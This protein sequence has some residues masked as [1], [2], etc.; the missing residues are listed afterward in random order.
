[1]QMTFKMR[2]I[3]WL[4]FLAILISCGTNGG[5][6]AE[7]ERQ[8]KTADSIS[9]KLNSPELKAINAKIL[10][11]PSNADLY[12]QR[13]IVYLG[14]REFQEAVNDSKR[15]IRIDSLQPPY[16]LTLADVY[17]AQNNTRL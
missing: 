1:M 7:L 17:F 13:S 9:I 5:D 15:A 4:P 11:D 10:A 8:S 16:Y 6:S 3:C 14:L 2:V 12:H